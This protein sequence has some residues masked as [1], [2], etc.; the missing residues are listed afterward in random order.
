MERLGYLMNMMSMN[1]SLFADHPSGQIEVFVEQVKSSNRSDGG[2]DGCTFNAKSFPIPLSTGKL[3]QSV[4]VVYRKKLLT[5]HQA[6]FDTSHI[7]H[8]A[9]QRASGIP[10]PDCPAESGTSTIVKSQ[11][12]SSKFPLLHAQAG[13]LFTR[14]ARGI[15]T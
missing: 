6:K 1:S 11:Q 14:S 4:L 3:P 9:S 8:K 10:T 12:A 2:C 13:F 7:S 5:D 15:G